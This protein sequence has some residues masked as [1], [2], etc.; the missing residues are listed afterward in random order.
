MTVGP[1]PEDGHWV[2]RWLSGPRFGVY[3][4]ACAGERRRAVALY[5]W[6][7][8]TAQ[9]FGLDLGHLEIAL[10]NAYD[11]AITDRWHGTRHWLSDPTSPVRRPLMRHGTDYNGRRR[12]QI[13]EAVERA[14]GPEAPPGKIIAEL[15]FGF[16]RF[17]TSASRHS[18]LWM[19]Y[20]RH[21]FPPGTARV[22]VDHAVTEMNQIR[23]R[24]AHHESLLAWDL[25]ANHAQLMSLVGLLNPSLAELIRATTTLPDQLRRRPR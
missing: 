23:N 8:V 9:A 19:P 11:V 10:R 15:A 22:T 13:A 24:I 5:Q 17:L 7:A 21:A 14:G 20:L 25:T 16:W 18:S 6:N 3:L 4:R 2:E 1:L 12:Q